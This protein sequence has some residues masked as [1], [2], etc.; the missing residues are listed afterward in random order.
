M[1]GTQGEEVDETRSEEKVLSGSRPASQSEA[2]NDVNAGSLRTAA[3]TIDPL[4]GGADDIDGK[5][6][7]GQ[8]P[9]C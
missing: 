7:R 9:R 5:A 2:N 4:G 6:T 3:P 1:Q 8:T